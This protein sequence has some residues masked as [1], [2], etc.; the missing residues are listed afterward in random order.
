MVHIQ[1]VQNRRA[2]SSACPAL[3]PSQRAS[4]SADAPLAGRSQYR[5]RSGRAET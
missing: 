3:W 4:D 2:V 5:G 1:I